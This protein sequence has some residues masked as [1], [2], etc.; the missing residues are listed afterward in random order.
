MTKEE[1]IRAY[2]SGWEKK[3]RSAVESML[4][5]GFAFTSPQR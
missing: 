3:Q 4:A 1:I 5:D 2:Y